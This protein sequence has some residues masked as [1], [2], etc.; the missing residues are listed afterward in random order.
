MPG[1]HINTAN[2]KDNVSCETLKT[3]FI[4]RHIIYDKIKKG[5]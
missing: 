2:K 4:R 5:D 1:R 3:F